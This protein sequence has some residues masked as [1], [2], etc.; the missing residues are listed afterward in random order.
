MLQIH[1]AGA[2]RSG[3]TTLARALRSKLAER[4]FRPVLIDVDEVKGKLFEGEDTGV[5][6]SEKSWRCHALAVRAMFG[7]V[8][9]VL[10]AGGAPIVVATHSGRESYESACAISNAF[11]TELHFLVVEAP[12][13]EE[14]AA[15][16]RNASSS[17]QS[18]MKDFGNPDI[19]RRCG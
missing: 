15:R 3:K 7:V 14:A 5:P 12:S 2:K 6:D 9:Y 13:V 4:S 17:D 16:A 18:D 1:V 11:H 19:R 8:P 10:E